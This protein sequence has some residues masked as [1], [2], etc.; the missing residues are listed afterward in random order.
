MKLLIIGHSVA[1]IIEKDGAKIIQPGGLFYTASVLK[2]LSSAEDEIFLCTQSDDQ[3]YHLYK[4]VYEGFDLTFLE[5]V[6]SIPVVELILS[7]HFERKEHY[8]NIS[9]KLSIEFTKLNDFDGILINMITGFDINLEQIKSIRQSTNAIIYFDVHTLSRGLDQFMHREF[10]QIPEFDQWAKNIDIIQCNE[11]EIFSLSEKQNETEIV[12]ELF[13][14]GVRIV[15]LTKGESGVRIFYSHENEI[16][17]YF[18]ATKKVSYN[19]KVG[20]GDAF[21][22]AFFYGYISHRN[23]YKAA[24]LASSSAEYTASIMQL[25]EIRKLK[26]NVAK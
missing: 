23:I 19:N 2:E 12:E 24:E 20:C 3:Y 5:K 4:N 21:G 15:C 14:Y 6:S 22:A 11:H 7:G 18:R 25:S 10:R 9:G 17:S 13:S 1:D 8:K 26:A 16:A